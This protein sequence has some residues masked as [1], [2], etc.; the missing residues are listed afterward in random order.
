MGATS[1][2]G[3]NWADYCLLGVVGL[4][5][6]YG[7]SR[8]L[9]REVFSLALWIGAAWVALQYNHVLAP[10]L[11]Q[12][13]PLESARLAAAFAAIYLAVLLLGGM[14]VSLLARLASSAGLGGTDRLAGLLFGL[15]RGALAG[16]ILV[17]L[18]GTTPLPAE[19]WWK[20]SK[21]IPTFQTLAVWLRGKLP[22][23]LP[24]RLKFP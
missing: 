3:L 21:L 24:A 9:V 11:E 20:Q 7:T 10:R 2:A 23:G 12:T 22:D 8:G 5:A 15:A 13:I 4:S 14:V 16:T 6:V 1:L 17:M 19:P 18:A